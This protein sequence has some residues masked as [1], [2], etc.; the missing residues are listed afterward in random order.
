MKG[1]ICYF[2]GS[3]NTQLA[4]RYIAGKMKNIEFD[5]FDIIEGGIPD[6]EKYDVVGF[7]TF[8]NY[9]GVQHIFQSFI[10]KLPRQDDRPSFVFNTYGFMSGKT[11]LILDKLVTEKGFLVI[12]GHSLH[13]P[14]SYPPMIVRGMGNEKAP[15]EKEM[16]RFNKFIYELDRLIAG[17]ELKRKN[18]W[19]GLLNRL[20]PAFSVTKARKDMGEKF[21]D[22]AL[23]IECGVCEKLCP[24]KAIRCSP[25]PVFD[26]NNCYACW[27]CYNHC[28]EKAIYASKYRGAGHYPKPINQ[29]KEKLK[30]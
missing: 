15:N 20:V 22:E 27:I 14:E 19:P 17:R 24:Y 29:L 21:V 11:L 7:A 1:I 12:A 26:M 16:R 4:C 8:T 13:T 23:C 18:I 2:S 30:A 10:G 9:G 3:G 6:L 5:L 28:P 25:K